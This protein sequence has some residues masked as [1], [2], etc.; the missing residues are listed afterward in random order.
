[1]QDSIGVVIP[2][3]NKR[4]YIE[5]AIDSVLRQSHESFAL[6]VI[7]DGST[8]D[9][10]ECVRRIS[11]P[12]LSL[13]RTA[14]FGPGAAR[15]LGLRTSEAD[16]I[17]FLDGD[18]CWHESFLEKTVDAARRHPNVVAVFTDVRRGAKTARRHELTSG[19]IEDYL[20]ARMGRNI[21]MSSSTILV[22]RSTFASLGGF[23]EDVRYAEDLEAWFRLSCEGPSYYICEPLATIEAH[24]PTSIT[25]ATDSMSRVEGLQRL[26]ETYEQYKQS[27]RIPPHCTVSS[28]RFMQHQRGRLALHLVS[29]G[30]R[31]AGLRTLLAGVPPGTH[32]W[33]EYLQCAAA[34]V[35]AGAH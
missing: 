23:R 19:V 20:G 6:T 16:W 24:D 22:R 17:A 28:R 8:D 25:R 32:T 15:N 34:L 29:A 21:S 12:R 10:V 3:H 13:L 2:L 11:D 27:A 31:R 1:M 18:D 30:R 7:D 26:L 14:C 9:S 5:R 35:R 4:A 33:R